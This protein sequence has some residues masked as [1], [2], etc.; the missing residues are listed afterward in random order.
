MG[1]NNNY[2]KSYKKLVTS[3]ILS[4]IFFLFIIFATRTQITKGYSAI[5][6]NITFIFC[7]ISYSNRFYKNYKFIIDKN[8]KECSKRSR[9]IEIALIII[10]ATLA[11]LIEIFANES[12]ANYF[13]IGG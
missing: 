5:F 1:L 8:Y 7:F 4:S 11:L 3:Y 10:L 12:V 6:F 9:N 13:S 2:N